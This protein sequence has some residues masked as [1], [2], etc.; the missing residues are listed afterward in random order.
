MQ[1]SKVFSE[2]SRGIYPEI[3][4]YGY[5]Y[6]NANRITGADY[7]AGNKGNWSHAANRFDVGGIQ[8]D[9][10][11]NILKLN[12]NGLVQQEGAVSTYKDMD[13]LSYGYSGN[14][15]IRIY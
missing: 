2:S 13:R 8:Y 11:G 9:L 6:D 1:N 14:R 5:R 4:V 10:N 15:L 7:V 3:Q 12:R